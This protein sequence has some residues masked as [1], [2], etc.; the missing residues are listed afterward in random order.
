L[1]TRFGEIVPDARAAEAAVGRFLNVIEERTGLL[2][3]RGEGVYVFSHLTFQEYL[4]ALALAA[5]DDYVAYTLGRTADPWWREVI[6]LEAGYLSTQS[7]ERTTR[8]IR[9]IADRVEEPQLYHNLVLA[10]EC[11]RDVGSGR[12]KGNLEAEVQAHLRKELDTPPPRGLLAPVQILFTRGMTARALTE[13]RL[14]AAR[15]LAQI[16]GNRF[17]SLPYGEPEWVSIADGEFWMGDTADAHR[18]D[19]RAFQIS[20]VPIT[21][22]QYQL[23]VEKTAHD[24][25]EHWE[26]GRPPKGLESHPVVHVSWHD[27]LAYCRWLSQVTGKQITLPSEAQW[28]KAARGDRDK[29]EYPWGDVFDATKCNC[30]ALGLGG[31]TPVGI[32]V[33]GASPYGVLDMSGNVW[34]WCLSKERNDTNTAEDNDPEGDDARVLRGGAF[35]FEAG[36]VRCAFRDW[37]FPHFRYWLF[38]FRVVASPV[39]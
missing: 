28:E 32:F 3:A 4:A 38:G 27:A 16:G 2:M 11:L 5:R 22:A 14:L 7:Q 35:D 12:V 13:R 36:L 15:A 34:E 26:E 8:L 20:R 10:S 18:V 19:L 30:E 1:A 23:F 6:L 21:N 39:S 24:A 31:T 37:D 9:A 33:E 25:P 29:R 17:W